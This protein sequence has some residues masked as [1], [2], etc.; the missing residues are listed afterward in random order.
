MKHAQL[1]AE[2]RHRERDAEYGHQIKQQARARGAYPDPFVK[3][4]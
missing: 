2:K 3:S 4:P 1:L